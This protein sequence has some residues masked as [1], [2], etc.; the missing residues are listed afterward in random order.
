MKKL[1]TFFTCVFTF[2]VTTSSAQNNIEIFGTDMWP[3]P[4]RGH[5]AK[6][7]DVNFHIK[8]QGIYWQIDLF[9][10]FSAANSG[11]LYSGMPY[12]IILDFTLPEGSI[13]YD[14]WLWMEDDSTIVRAD[15]YEKGEATEVYEGLVNRQIDP[16]LLY[17]KGN[18]GYQLR[19]FPM[20][21]DGHR[22]VKLSYMIPTNF[23]SNSIYALLPLE[24]LTANS[25]NWGGENFQ[26]VIFDDANYNLGLPTVSHTSLSD[27]TYVV[28]PILGNAWMGSFPM[29]LAAKPVQISFANPMNT[30]GVFGTLMQKD[31]EQFYQ[32]AYEKP[33]ATAPNVTPKQVLVVVD[34]NELYT[35]VEFEDLIDYLQTQL[36]E[37]LDDNDEFNLV[38]ASDNT[39]GG[40]SPIDNWLSTT[41]LSADDAT[42]NQEFANTN[43][44][45]FNQSSNN[46]ILPQGMTYMDSNLDPQAEPIVIWLG[47]NTYYDSNLS[48]ITSFSAPVFALNYNTKYFEPSWWSWGNTP[49]DYHFY[50]KEATEDV[51]QS[52]GGSSYI[53]MD[54]TGSLWEGIQY[55]FRIAAQSSTSPSNLGVNPN[56]GFVYDEYEFERDN[57]YYQVGKYYGNAPFTIQYQEYVNNTVSTHTASISASAMVV[58]DTLQEE[59]WVGHYLR[60]LESASFVDVNHIINV[61]KEER[62]L[63]DRYTAFLALD[64]TQGGEPCKDCWYAIS[65]GVVVDVD[66]VQAPK[67]VQTAVELYPNPATTFC[68][69]EWELEE[70]DEILQAEV[71]S[72]D[73]RVVKRFDLNNFKEQV[74]Q[75]QW[76]LQGDNG[77][78]LATGVYMLRIQTTRQQISQQLI[79]QE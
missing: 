73:G 31:G 26:L 68:T 35:D 24:I 45:G 55:F 15:V 47:S 61:S 59:I 36:I 66:E 78:R 63:S 50:M 71:Y 79:I 10:T 53:T 57:V 51:A 67:A 75:L 1:F 9:M 65:G 74:G 2:F 64:L 14:S 27:F 60:D 46:S 16:S 21:H 29:S 25:N 18:G 6:M 11:N 13:M 54:G 7:S 48:S 32:L 56:A 19:V 42:I 49:G 12:E 34:H 33:T 44:S 43:F 39:T 52:S 62:V 77:Q 4:G 22:K 28:D 23:N 69:I 41:W 5:V 76:D 58:A 3:S 37:Y 30:D 17:R 38:F 20:A 72:V 8:P 40:G 70:E